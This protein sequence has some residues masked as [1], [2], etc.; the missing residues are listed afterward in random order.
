[1]QNRYPLSPDTHEIVHQGLYFLVIRGPEIVDILGIRGLTHGIGSGEG[2]EKI[3]IPGREF[4]QEGKYPGGGGSAYIIEKAEYVVLPDELYGILHRGTGVIPVV[5]GQNPY[6]SP[7]YAALLVYFGEIG[8]RPAIELDSQAPG[9]PAEGPGH[10]QDNI[11]FLP[12]QGSGGK[13]KQKECRKRREYT[14][15]ADC[16]YIA[17]CHWPPQGSPDKIFREIISCRQIGVYLKSPCVKSYSFI[18][19]LKP[20]PEHRNKKQSLDHRIVLTVFL[21]IFYKISMPLLGL[22]VLLALNGSG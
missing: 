17:C 7:V 13:E 5:I 9:G 2:T 11:P 20:S 15:P 10:A 21:P 18:Q 19:Y 22:P 8:I 14:R 6:L 4:G 1:V 12:G 16:P 3:N